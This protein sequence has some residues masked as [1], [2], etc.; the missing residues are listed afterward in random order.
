MSYWHKL[1]DDRERLFWLLHTCGWIGFALIYYIGSFLHDMRPIWIFVIILN[2]IAGWVLTIPLRY[3]FR[4]VSSLTPW[5]IVIA[6][7]VSIYVISLLWTVAKNVHYWEIYKHGYR[8]DEWY[9]YLTNS[10]NSVFLMTCWSG[11]Y[12]GIKNYQMLQKEKQNALKASAM[13]H[14]AQI[15]M[16]RYQLNPHFLFNTLNAISTLILMKDYET[17]SG[18]VS[19]LSDF[20][21]YSLDKDPIKKVPLQQ[22]IKALELYLDIE[23][24]RFDTR[25]TVDWQIQEEA[26]QALV[27]SLILQPLI[28]NAIKYAISK[29][30]MGGII[31]IAAQ[32]QDNDLLLQ[33]EDNG[34]GANI[35]DG[36]LHRKNGVGLT[37]IRERLKSLY[38]SRYQFEI[39]HNE[40]TGVKVT[41]RIPLDTNEHG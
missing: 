1:I 10:A 8:P 13:A 31:R 34:P 29:L 20:L 24:V 18:M 33:V 26:K 23:K 28:E 36:Q 22:E 6:V 9:M 35:V 37:N 38:G 25:L 21:R 16:L 32:V 12:F 4:A 27:P 41:I 11:L 5:K 39:A 14:Q 2:S 15:K 17:A 7:M 19:R 30:E 40:P 3:V